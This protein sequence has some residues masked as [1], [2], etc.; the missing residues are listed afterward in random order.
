MLK[1]LKEYISIKSLAGDEV[2]NRKALDFL[3]KLFDEIDFTTTVEG[4][5]PHYQPTLIAKYLNPNS[6]KKVVLYSH[7]DVE[8][9]DK[10]KWI[11][12]NPF[13][14]EEVNG[15]LYGRGIADNK[16]IFIARYTAI[17]SMI[18]KGEEIPSILW[19]IQGEEE[20]GGL[21]PF[22]VFPKYISEFNAKLFVEETAYHN[23]GRQL[24]L[25]LPKGDSTFI[26][27]LSEKVLNSPLIENRHLNKFFLAGKCP[28][29]ENI[30]KDALYIGFGPNDQDSNIHRDNES[31]DKELLLQHLQ[32]FQ[33]FL[34]FIL[35]CNEI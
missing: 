21:A 4:Y 33:S 8:K 23:R 34:K 22:E 19:L 6:S 15:R 26:K 10:K 17:K 28:F 30:P 2:E 18:E 27:E 5:S 14:M 32:Q 20:V 13:E 31:L 25:S 7:Y 9:I 12:D 16:G 3:V 35:E 24:L 29:L 1:L 11:I